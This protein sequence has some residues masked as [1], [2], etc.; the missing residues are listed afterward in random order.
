MVQLLWQ[1]L[2]VEVFCYGKL[3]ICRSV[4]NIGLTWVGCTNSLSFFFNV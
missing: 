3:N 1:V 2:D 4:G